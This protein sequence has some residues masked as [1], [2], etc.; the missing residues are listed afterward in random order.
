MDSKLVINQLSWE[1]KIKKDELKSINK[2]IKEII[3][4]FKITV[5]YIWIRREYNKQADRLSNVA[6]NKKIGRLEKGYIMEK[7][8]N[9]IGGVSS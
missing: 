9:E 3:K 6:M 5:N 7:E 2:D 4:K 8:R 1:W